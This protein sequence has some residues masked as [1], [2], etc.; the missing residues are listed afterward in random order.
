MARP[1]EAGSEPDGPPDVL[2]D[3]AELV[4]VHQALTPPPAGE[5]PEEPAVRLPVQLRP[6]D[7]PGRGVTP[8]LDD[9]LLKV[10]LST[11]VADR[12]MHAL[13]VSHGRDP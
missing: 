13:T 4:G 12:G 10:Q 1:I 6:D 8:R 3:R 2:L 7:R 5:D 9:P 11:G